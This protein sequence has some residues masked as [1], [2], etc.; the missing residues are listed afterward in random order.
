M[1]GNDE[2][3]CI[4]RVLRGEVNA[5]GTLQSHVPDGGLVREGGRPYPGNLHQSLPKTGALSSGQEILPLA[6]LHWVEPCQRL[7]P[8]KNLEP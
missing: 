2:Q 6:L 4:D 7:C 3:N 8:K 1:D 5:F